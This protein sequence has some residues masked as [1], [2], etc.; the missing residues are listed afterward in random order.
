MALSDTAGGT[1][2]GALKAIVTGCQSVAKGR[3]SEETANT[4][5]VYNTAMRAGAVF[6]RNTL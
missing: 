6:T 4:V 5:Q 3:Q 2:G 1:G